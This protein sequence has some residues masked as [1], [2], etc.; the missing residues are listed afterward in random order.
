MTAL[1]VGIGLIIISVLM[2][3]PG[4]LGW[5]NDVLAF[6]RG[7]IPVFAVLIGALA[8]FIGIADIKDK[9]EEKKEEEKSKN[10]ENE[11]ETKEEKKD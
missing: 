6:L 4:V 7:A 9:I 1:L 8:V 10:A 5:W 2:V 3:L 11:Q